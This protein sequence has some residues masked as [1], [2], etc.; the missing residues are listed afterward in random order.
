MASLGRSRGHQ[1]APGH[2]DS[3]G[4]GSPV[5]RDV[6]KYLRRAL[7]NKE[8]IWQ[9]MSTAEITRVRRDWAEGARTHSNPIL[10]ETA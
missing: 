9:R 10:P 3:K 4:R 7:Q 2:G 5:P 8:G 1:G 6:M